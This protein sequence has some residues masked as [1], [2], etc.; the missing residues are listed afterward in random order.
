MSLTYRFKSLNELAAYFEGK[1]TDIRK[2]CEGSDIK[3]QRRREE[4][5]RAVEMESIAHILRNTEIKP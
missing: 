2:G 5:I 4:L 3:K 1:A